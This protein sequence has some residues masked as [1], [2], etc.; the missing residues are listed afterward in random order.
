MYISGECSGVPRQCRCVCVFGECRC[1]YLDGV[2][3]CIIIFS[4]FENVDKDQ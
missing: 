1:M 4:A 3:V 2:S